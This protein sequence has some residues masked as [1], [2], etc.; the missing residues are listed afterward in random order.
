MTKVRF[1]S[2][3]PRSKSR[4]SFMFSDQLPTT[5]ISHTPESLKAATG[6]FTGPLHKVDLIR[7]ARSIS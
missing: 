5:D 1:T 2:L 7:V 4:P 6:S 3:T